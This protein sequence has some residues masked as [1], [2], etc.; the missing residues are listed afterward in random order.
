[1]N[2][3]DDISS[4]SK[5]IGFVDFGITESCALPEEQIRLEAYL[6]AGYHGQMDYLARNVA[7]RCNPALLV[8]KAASIWIFLAPYAPSP[9]TPAFGRIAGFAQGLDYHDQIKERLHQ[10]LSRIRTHFPEADGRAFTDSAPLLERTWAVRCGL[11]FIGRNGLLIHPEYGSRVLIGALV[12][13]LPIGTLETATG[14]PISHLRPTPPR[15]LGC[16]HCHRCLEHC[17]GQALVAPYCLDARRC[18]SYQTLEEPAMLR[19]Q[20]KR[21]RGCAPDRCG[22]TR[23]IG[24]WLYGCDTCQEVCPWNHKAKTATWTE[25]T[26]YQAELNALTQ[27]DWQTLDL[28]SLRKRF[29]RSP[30]LRA[31]LP[32]LEDR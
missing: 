15:R 32:Q 23:P 20:A 16:G 3:F 21:E 10:V 4:F 18:V 25:F 1:M 17:P 13:N 30:L 31:G 5:S 7:M 8:E 29:P 26:Q 6:Q 2:F 22:A 19:S 14:Q 27:A 24:G 12:L 28:E 11:G 9:Q